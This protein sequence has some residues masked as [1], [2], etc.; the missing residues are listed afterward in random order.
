MSCPDTRLRLIFS[1]FKV[2]R[3][4]KRAQTI[5]RLQGG[6]TASVKNLLKGLGCTFK[7]PRPHAQLIVLFLRAI[8][9][10]FESTSLRLR[11]LG[12]REQACAVAGV[13]TKTKKRCQ[14]FM[15]F[16]CSVP[17]KPRKGG[18]QQNFENHFCSGMCIGIAI[19]MCRR[20]VRGKGV[21]LVPPKRVI[22][23]PPTR[24][25]RTLA[26]TARTCGPDSPDMWPGQPGHV[27]RT[28]GLGLWPGQPR[29][30]PGQPRLCPDSLDFSAKIPTI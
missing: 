3:W 12:T 18:R 15:I 4:S 1:P 28:A 25:P 27:A 20:D 29:L 2:G 23:V 13:C 19:R 5:P 9:P 24:T 14:M 10:A 7:G 16:A 26:R 8:R 17:P 30:W 22:L 6:R 21:I 11:G